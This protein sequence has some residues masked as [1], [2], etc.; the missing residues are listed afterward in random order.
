[1]WFV[2]ALR[3]TAVVTVETVLPMSVE[4]VEPSPSWPEEFK[5]QHFTAPSN[6][7][8]ECESPATM[9]SAVN[10]ETTAREL[11]TMVPSPSWAD[12]LLPT[13]STVLSDLRK[14]VWLPPAAIDVIS[15]IA[16]AID[17]LAGSTVTGV[18]ESVVLPLPS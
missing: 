7:A 18:D 10:R 13:H 1:M 2:P 8:H 6:K 15:V 17:G 12:K 16:G 9:A 11:D 14:H 4:L 5:P 3:E